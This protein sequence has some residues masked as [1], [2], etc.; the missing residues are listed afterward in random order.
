MED[1]RFPFDRCD[2]INW[3]IAITNFNI[4]FKCSELLDQVNTLK[5]TIQIGYFKPDDPN[6]I[7]GR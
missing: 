5:K 7:D 2:K 1:L 3:F 6:Y 4:L